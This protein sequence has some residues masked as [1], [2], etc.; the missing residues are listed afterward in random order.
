MTVKMTVNVLKQVTFGFGHDPESDVITFRV[1][2]Q[3]NLQCLFI[4]TSY[5]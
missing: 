4:M 1:V 5:V 2:L 3:P